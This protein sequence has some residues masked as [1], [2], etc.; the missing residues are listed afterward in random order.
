MPEATTT[1]TATPAPST[2]TQAS[3]PAG[4]GEGFDVRS[5]LGLDSGGASSGDGDSAA[6]AVFGAAAAASAEGGEQSPESAAAQAALKGSES[7][8]ADEAEAEA[9]AP[10]KAEKTEASQ[11]TEGAQE[12]PV[13]KLQTADG[14][15]IEIPE[16]A[17]LKVKVDG[18]V[19][20][21]TLQDLQKDYAGKV[22]YE[23]KYKELSV[24]RE[25]VKKDRETFQAEVK[26]IDT[27]L[28]E[29]FELA[30]TNPIACYERLVQMAGFDSKQSFSKYM[31]QAIQAVNE[32]SKMTPEQRKLEVD[33]RALARERSDLENDKKKITLTKEE[34]AAQEYNEKVCA[35]D[36]LTA[37][38]FNDGW[39]K[40]RKLAEEGQIDLK[41][42]T[43][44]DLAELVAGYIK[45][46]KKCSL[47]ESGLRQVDP[48]LV[49][50][51]KLFR[52]IFRL[53]PED[54]TAEDVADIARELTGKEQA[55]KPS[56]DMGGVAKT[57]RPAPR[58]TE[59]TASTEDD[60]M[61]EIARSVLENTL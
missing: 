6:N 2:G 9:A 20:E 16:N 52:E 46:D 58:K 48:K 60:E 44:K 28:N 59:K 15:S 13:V 42:K 29:V 49:T 8:E 47:I 55:S 57:T 25:T 17:K 50:N 1:T 32:W 36:G 19:Q 43:T 14:K 31:D 23:R 40:V 39:T 24:E 12:V 30:K 54:F 35:R 34:R 18:K 26:Q 7:Q 53:V 3:T 61:R 38:E 33:R 21:V 45:S 37:E 10:E 56:K 41:G 22:A 27:Q 11:E 51:E 5:F 4:G